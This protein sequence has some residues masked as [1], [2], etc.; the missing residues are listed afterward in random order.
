MEDAMKELEHAWE[1]LR[2][3]PVTD[4]AVDAMA[5]ARIHLQRVYTELKRLKSE[6]VNTNG[7]RV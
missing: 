1:L 7:N 2:T 6:E 4:T 5:A 3:I